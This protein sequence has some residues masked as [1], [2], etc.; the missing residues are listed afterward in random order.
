MDPLIE[1]SFRPGLMS[2]RPSIKI[3]RLHPKGVRI[4]P[5]DAALGGLAPPSARRYCG[6]Y[7]HANG[8]GFYLYSPIDI[9]LSFDPTR[10]LP[11]NWN[12]HGDGY[13]DDEIGVL[14]SMPIRHPNFRREMI[15]RRPK[16]FLSGV[17]DEPPQTAQIW[18]GCIFQT[19]PGWALWLRGPINR[20]FDAP[21]R[22]DEAILETEWL[23]YDVWLNLRFLRFGEVAKIRRDGPPLAHLVPVPQESYG[24]A[25][26]QDRLLTPDDPAAQAVFDDW[27]EFNWL[28]FHSR[29]DGTKDQTVY[30]RQRKKARRAKAV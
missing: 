8:A 6:P 11:W 14:R 28:K 29:D 5:A 24:S 22:I 23:H 2:D 17:D 4:E 21:F 3:W 26:I 10:E 20:E 15:K 9:D 25:Q 1:I 19:P 18:T 12:I 30:H 13:A 16:L 27:V 7:M